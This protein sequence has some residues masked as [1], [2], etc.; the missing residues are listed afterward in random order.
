MGGGDLQFGVRDNARRPEGVSAACCIRARVGDWMR[1][2][3]M[4]ANDGVFEGNQYTPPRYVNL[5]LR[6]VRKESSR[7]FFTR[8]D[9][10][11]AA[12]DVAWLEGSEQQRLW[13]VPSLKLAILRL[14]REAE[15]SKE[16]DEAMIPDTIIRGTSGWKPASPGEGVDPGR[17]APH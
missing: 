2:G 7:G 15:G 3:E 14:G 10:E 6:P 1:I 9:G 16:W 11:F 12:R 13:I 17:F 4:L 5:M 8:V